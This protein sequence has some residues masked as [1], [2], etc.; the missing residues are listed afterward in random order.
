[1]S[2]ELAEHTVVESGAGAGQERAALTI[3]LPEYVF[4]TLVDQAAERAAARL[5]PQ[6]D[7]M[8]TDEVADY[9]H[10]PKKRI[11]NLCSAGTIP[12]RKIGGRRAFIRHEIDAWVDAQP[13]ITVTGALMTI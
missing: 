7:Y 6:R 11:D 9:L 5:E 4:E 10:W 1:M 8:T 12:Y 2:S 3:D 13:G